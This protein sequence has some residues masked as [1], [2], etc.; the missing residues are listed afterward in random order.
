MLAFLIIIGV[1]SMLGILRKKIISNTGMWPTFF[2][3]SAI[4][5][6]QSEAISM[7]EIPALSLS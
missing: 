1:M 3:I 5:A 7:K 2:I 6:K 4:K